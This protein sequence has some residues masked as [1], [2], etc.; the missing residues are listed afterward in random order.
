[1]LTEGSASFFSPLD[2]VDANVVEVVHHPRLVSTTMKRNFQVDIYLPVG[3]RKDL[4]TTYPWLIANDGQDMKAV[5]LRETLQDLQRRGLMAPV[6]VLAIHAP[7]DRKQVYGVAAEPD[8]KERG[9]LAGQYADFIR[10]EAIP[11]LMKEYRVKREA[12]AIMGFS[13]G[14]L[15]AFD[16]AWHQP[17]LF[18]VVGVFSGSFWWRRKG[19]DQG[20]TDADRIM[21]DLVLNG[22]KPALKYWLQVGTHDER[23]DRDKDGVIDAVGDTRDLVRLLLNKG[24]DLWH[25]IRYL[26]VP[27]GHHNQQTWGEVLPD[28]LQWA[29]GTVKPQYV[30]GHQPLQN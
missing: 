29:F 15:Q 12:G 23:D 30:W 18:N 8:F 14:G 4:S 19:Y 9:A 22:N 11:Y 10:H 1:M 20:Y 16:I 5:N 2:K 3:Y 25:D 7:T 6:V 13:L 26:E 28:F 27:N 21:L 24:Y 17:E